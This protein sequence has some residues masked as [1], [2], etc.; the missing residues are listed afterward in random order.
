MKFNL[1]NDDKLQI[2]ISRDDLAE[3][4][5]KKW[6]L[7]PYSPNSQKIFQEIL[8]EA[9]EVCGFEVGRDAQLMIEAYPMTGESM[10]ITVTKVGG[11]EHKSVFGMELEDLE[12]ALLEETFEEELFLQNEERVCL[13]Y[14]LEDAI[15]LAKL[16]VDGYVGSSRLYQYKEKYYLAF[17]DAAAFEHMYGAFL[18]EYGDVLK[19]SSAFLEEHGRCI[20]EEN[21]VGVLAEL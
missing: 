9:Y 2:I 15:Q 12:D 5:I 18:A 16:V 20:M 4:D 8:E 11:S 6:D 21:A 1:V 3:R 10:I 19:I 17:T 13:L 14:T 7:V